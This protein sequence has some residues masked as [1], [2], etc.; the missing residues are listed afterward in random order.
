MNNYSFFIRYSLEII[1]FGV[2]Q[3][4]CKIQMAL[5]VNRVYTLSSIIYVP[6]KDI[7]LQKLKQNSQNIVLKTY[8][9]HLAGSTLKCQK[10]S[11]VELI[12]NTY[13]RHI[14]TESVVSL[15]KY[16]KQWT[17]LQASRALSL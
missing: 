1:Y 16:L 15:I 17:F 13:Q 7:L 4:N 14:W 11:T 9:L 2:I 6:F 8:D 5:G 12:K 10:I 3:Q